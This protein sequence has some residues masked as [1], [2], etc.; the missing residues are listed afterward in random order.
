M[1]KIALIVALIVATNSFADDTADVKVEGTV[2]FILIHI[3]K[4]PSI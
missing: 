3:L 4:V 1:M 2:L